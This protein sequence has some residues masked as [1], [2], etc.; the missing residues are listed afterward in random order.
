MWLY[1]YFY[2]NQSG[3]PFSDCVIVLKIKSITDDL[4]YAKTLFISKF[5]HDATLL[6][7][8]VRHYTEMEK[9]FCAAKCST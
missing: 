6:F 4:V 3:L 8:A 2:V 9:S 5:N 1:A 7:F